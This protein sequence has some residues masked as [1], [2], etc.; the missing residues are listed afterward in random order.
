MLHPSGN[1]HT[2]AKVQNG[3]ERIIQLSS[4]SDNSEQA[5]T[6]AV[7]HYQKQRDARGDYTDQRD[8]VGVAAHLRHHHSLLQQIFGTVTRGIKNRF[9]RHQVTW[10]PT[11][12]ARFVKNSFEHFAKRTFTNLFSSGH[13]MPFDFARHACYG[14][15]STGVDI[16]NTFASACPQQNQLGFEIMRSHLV[17]V[18]TVFQKH[19]HTNPKH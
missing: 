16:C 15:G 8:Q 6:F 7:R 10:N 19:H 14:R 5:S 2:E 17:L 1:L 12:F 3:G 11:N 18:C 4:V 13:T 9:A